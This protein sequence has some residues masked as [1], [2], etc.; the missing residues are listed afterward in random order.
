GGAYATGVLVLITSAAFAVTISVWN[1]R[2]RWPF[3]FISLIF[4]YTTVLNVYERPEGIKIA[5]FFIATIVTT[6]LVSRAMRSTELRITWVHLDARA[7][8]LLAEDEDQEIHILAR[9]PGDDREENLDRADRQI[10]SAH[11]L[12]D[13]ERVYFFEVERSDASSFEETLQ[14]DGERVGKHTVLRA[15]S[16][17]VA[18]SIAALLMYLKE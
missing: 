16:P 2:A 15:R 11:H 8:A 12:P 14:V 17:V 13:D 7:Q 18:N 6:S 3:L 10:R 4:T 1:N 9:K 5:S